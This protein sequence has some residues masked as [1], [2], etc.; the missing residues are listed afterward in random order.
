MIRFSSAL[1]RAKAALQFLLGVAIVVALGLGAYKL[2]PRPKPPTGWIHVLGP[3]DTLTLAQHAGEIWAGGPEGL[4]G[5]DL[6][7]AEVRLIAPSGLPL[8]QVACIHTS[9]EETWVGHKRGVSRFD[10][11]AWTTWTDSDGLPDR[12]VWA[13][14]KLRDGTVWVGTE[15]GAAKWVSDHWEVL[16]SRNG[17]AND[18][19]TVLFEDSRGRIWLGNGL[20]MA[21]GLSVL[22]AGAW[23]TFGAPNELPHAMVNGI[24]EDAQG[25][26]WV[27][28]GF[29]SRGGA[30]HFDGSRWTSILKRDGLAGD[31]VRS[32]FVDG[33][34]AVWFGAEYD[35]A[36]RLDGARWSYLATT[37]G[38]PG[39]EVK[40]MVQ[41]TDGNLW[42]GTERGIG[43]LAAGAS[44]P[45]QS[46]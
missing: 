44:A 42:F 7:T 23:K 35:G 17:P 26:I 2:T 8:E 34:G 19:V 14:R 32:V 18:A 41:D 11:K 5:I 27:G 24:A 39:N 22:E 1:R 38:L 16:T 30:A 10:G 36:A 25:N 43:R 9:G 15:R 37:S 21:G 29:S 6:R 31:K 4:S 12:Q 40:A 3:G 33:A 13:V 46:P 20:T 45:G 28:T